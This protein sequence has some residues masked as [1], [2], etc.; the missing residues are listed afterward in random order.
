MRQCDFCLEPPTQ[1]VH[2][3]LGD[4]D[5]ERVLELCDEHTRLVWRTANPETEEAPVK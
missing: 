2:V 3:R 5:E 1:I 4:G